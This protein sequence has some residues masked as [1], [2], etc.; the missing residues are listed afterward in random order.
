MIISKKQKNPKK[1]RIFSNKYIV[2]KIKEKEIG[3]NFFLASLIIFKFK[4]NIILILFNLFYNKNINLLM[5]K[6][7]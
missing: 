3:L 2:K 5:K 7:I 4:W 6:K 1:I